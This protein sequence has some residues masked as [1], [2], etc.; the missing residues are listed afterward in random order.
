MTSELQQAFDKMVARLRDGKGRATVIDDETGYYTCVYR[1][2]HGIPCVAGVLLD[3]DHPAANPEYRKVVNELVREYPDET[4]SVIRDNLDFIIA[5][6]VRH[7]DSDNW[8]GNDF[9]QT[10]E[11]ELAEIAS[12]YNLN[13]P[14]RTTT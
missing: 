7:D 2:H 13:L 11:E 9:N 8:T 6:Q 14:E 10:G 1:D 12:R 3:D 5:M 4:P